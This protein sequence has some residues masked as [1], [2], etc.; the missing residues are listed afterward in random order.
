[1]NF[2]RDLSVS[3]AGE[4]NSLSLAVVPSSKVRR[5]SLL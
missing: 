3:I 1:M 4:I 2:E 5:I